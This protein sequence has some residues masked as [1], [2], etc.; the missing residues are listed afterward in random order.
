[1]LKEPFSFFVAARLILNLAIKISSFAFKIAALI[2]F[3]ITFPPAF[4][5]NEI[6]LIP[7]FS[8]M[9][10]LF[11]DNLAF[12]FFGF[13]MFAL[14]FNR[15]FLAFIIAFLVL[16]PSFNFPVF[17]TLFNLINPACNTFKETFL[18]PTFALTL[19]LRLIF[20]G[21]LT[22]TFY[23]LPK[24]LTS[25]FALATAALNLIEPFAFFAAFDKNFKLFFALD[26]AAFD[27][28]TVDLESF[29]FTIFVTLL[30]FGF[31]AAA[32][33]LP[34]AFK[35][36]ALTVYLCPIT[37][38]RAAFLFLIST[39]GVLTETFGFLDATFGLFTFPTAFKN[40]ALTVYLCPITF[41]RAA[42]LFLISTIG[43]L[44]ETFGFLDETFG[45]L[46]TI[47]SFGFYTLIF[48]FNI[49]ETAFL[50]NL[51]AF[52]RLILIFF[53]NFFIFGDNL[54]LRTILANLPT[55]ILAFFT[56]ILIFAA[57]FLL[58][59]LIILDVLLTFLTT[60]FT[61]FLYFLASN[62]ILTS[63]LDLLIKF[64]TFL[65]AF[66]AFYTL[67]L[68]LI[69]TFF[70]SFN[71]LMLPEDFAFK[72]IFGLICDLITASLAS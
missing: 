52:R 2:F 11:I 69:I 71:L 63:I 66:A 18:S 34:T 72:E 7:E 53:A 68:N 36:P 49:V 42:F 41:F 33:M 27:F 50:V 48:K 8:L 17:M 23:F 4:N 46:T 15:A 20:I 37:F 51:L 21:F 56:L 16:A 38:F 22:I 9:A 10:T 67:N 70:F 43:V 19:C 5:Y 45:L 26:K 30:T 24:N 58:L 65:T 61:L 28:F 44:T 35:N 59:N 12:N 39:I 31:L 29:T 40:P 64:V 6:L 1:M 55:E 57:D 47:F 25:S 3:G 14:A 60:F 62:F 13:W 32:F 54:D